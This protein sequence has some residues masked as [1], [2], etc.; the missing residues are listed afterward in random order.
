MSLRNAPILALASGVP[1]YGWRPRFSSGSSKDPLLISG[2]LDA[3][4]W[5]CFKVGLPMAISLALEL[6]Y[7]KLP[8]PLLLHH[9][10]HHRNPPNLL[11]FLHCR[12]RSPLAPAI[13]C[14]DAF[15][16][17]PLCGGRHPNFLTTHSSVIIFT[18]SG[19]ERIWGS[20]VR[21]EHSILLVPNPRIRHHHRRRRIATN[22]RREA[23]CASMTARNR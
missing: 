12:L 6:P 22:P 23:L 1:L 14:F 18:R 15:I 9:H 16:L 19:I 21:I 5:K 10:H 17:T 4:C 3:L 8:P 7:S 20:T 11:V 13:S 2:L